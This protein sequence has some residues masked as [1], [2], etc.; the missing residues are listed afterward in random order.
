MFIDTFSNVIAQGL[1]QM[2]I[3]FNFKTVAEWQALF[4][5]HGWQV[6]RSL[7]MGFQANQFNRSCHIWFVLD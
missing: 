2:D 1:S 6:T 7:P 5:D 4:Q 3:P